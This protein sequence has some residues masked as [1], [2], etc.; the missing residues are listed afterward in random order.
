MAYPVGRFGFYLGA[1][2][3]RNKRQIRAELYIHGERAKAFFAL[4]EKQKGQIESE[5]GWSGKNYLMGG[6]PASPDTLMKLIRRTLQIGRAST[7]G[8]PRH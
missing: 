8:W 6:I 3:A 5:I 7:D 4:L 2:M 1:A